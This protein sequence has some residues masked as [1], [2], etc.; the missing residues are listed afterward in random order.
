MRSLL[1]FSVFA[2]VATSQTWTVGQSVKTTSGSVVGKGAG[3]KPEVSAYLGI[4][5]AESPIGKLRF[6]APVAFK[7][8]GT[9]AATKFGL[10]CPEDVGGKA[11]TMADVGD[12][13]LNLNVWTKPQTGEKAKAVMV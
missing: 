8:N 11:A 10:G 7:G 1:A 12:D 3:W 4:P 2:G 9:I 6:A 13:C 5:F